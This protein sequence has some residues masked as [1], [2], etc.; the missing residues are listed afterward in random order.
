MHINRYLPLLLP[1]VLSACSSLP[2]CYSTTEAK[3]SKDKTNS[4]P[5]FMCYSGGAG[6]TCVTKTSDSSALGNRDKFKAKPVV[7]V[8]QK[9]KPYSP[10]KTSHAAT[11]ANAQNQDVAKTADHSITREQASETF[12]SDQGRVLQSVPGHFYALQIASMR[13][14]KGAMKLVEKLD[15]SAATIIPTTSHL[16]TVHV[17]VLGYYPSKKEAMNAGQEYSTQH[18]MEFWSRRV[19]HL[20]DAA[21]L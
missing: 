19:H 3:A 2:Y 15:L 17:I 9:T 13:S 12:T 18:N 21:E 1:L 14:K 11:K 10:R 20:K 6:T 5:A 8:I 4:C 16:G 7:D